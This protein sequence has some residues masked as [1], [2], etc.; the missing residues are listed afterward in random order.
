MYVICKWVYPHCPYIAYFSQLHHATWKHFIGRWLCL[1]PLHSLAHE[2]ISLTAPCISMGAGPHCIRPGRTV[3]STC[4]EIFK[5]TSYASACILIAHTLAYF[6][7]EQAM[8]TWTL[9]TGHMCLW[10]THQVSSLAGYNVFSF[11]L[12]NGAAQFLWTQSFSFL[13]CQRIKNK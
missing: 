10:F 6:L 13:S 11:I 3:D 12:P 2:A 9:C 5:C 8:E 4:S 7:Q 1:Q